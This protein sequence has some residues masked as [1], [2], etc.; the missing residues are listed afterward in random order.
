MK[1]TGKEEEW[2]FRS[3]RT[4]ATLQPWLVH[5]LAC[6]NNFIADTRS[7]HLLCSVWKTVSWNFRSF[8]T[9]AW[10]YQVC[11]TR[12]PPGLQVA[13]LQWTL[14][15]VRFLSCIVY[16]TIYLHA[17]QI[18]WLPSPGCLSASL[19][20]TLQLPHPAR[21]QHKTTPLC[22]VLGH[23]AHFVLCRLP[24]PQS[25]LAWRMFTTHHIPC[26]HANCCRWFKTVPG[27][28]RHI[29]SA[30]NYSFD[31]SA[32]TS[33]SH[34]ESRFA[35]A[36]KLAPRMFC[37]YHDKLTGRSAALW[38]KIPYSNKIYRSNLWCKWSDY[39]F[40]NSPTASL[41][42]EPRWLGSIQ[43][44]IEVWNCRVSVPECRDV[45]W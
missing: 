42:E 5:T 38:Q 21:H 29:L 44:L 10:I 45:I 12:I 23:T 41:R 37:D 43:W 36:A 3:G 2:F 31:A 40:P 18:G 28:K 34:A 22:E 4:L 6:P 19:S 9:V 14:S 16:D 32:R 33:E 30:H 8:S 1:W 17:P 13:L 11:I 27:L 25:D 39:W 35:P 15:I 26:P 24:M 20:Q 7:N